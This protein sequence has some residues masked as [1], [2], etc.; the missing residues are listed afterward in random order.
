MSAEEAKGRGNAAL[1]AGRFD[2]AIAEYT[3]AI[4]LDANNAVY[5]SNRCAA[6]L[7]T[8]DNSNLAKA[9]ADADS[10]IENKRDWNKAYGR[11]GDVLSRMGKHS[12]AIKM[13]TTAVEYSS[14]P[15]E[16]AVY[17][18]NIKIVQALQV[19]A[20]RRSSALMGNGISALFHSGVLL[21]TLLYLVTG[22]DG[23][24]FYT[25]LKVSVLC[26]LVTI[27]RIYG[28]PQFNKE[29]FGRVVQH[30][31]LHY[32]LP[33]FAFH[34]SEPS[35][36]GLATMCMRAVLFICTVAPHFGAPSFVTAQTSK[37]ASAHRQIM[38]SVANLEVGQGFLLLLMLL[39]PGRNLVLTLVLWQYLRL[40]YMIHSDT[41]K[42]FQSV[43]LFLDGVFTHRLCPSFVN[44]VWQKLVTFISGF[45]DVQAAQNQRMCSVM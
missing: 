14:V 10:A 6:L 40:R 2:D 11:K 21:C 22:L 34:A 5:Y 45:G 20:S 15:N 26:Q 17:E 37:V 9:L 31:E 18:K 1:K 19:N 41:K 43:R 23:F 33:A 29:Y 35:L 13:Y 44:T 12:E 7:G 36:L 42:A 39:T 3:T 27:G 8:K 16:S 25:A 32:I 24:F 4:D 38:E 30:H 28:L